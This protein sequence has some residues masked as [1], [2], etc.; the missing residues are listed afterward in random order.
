MFPS[1][2]KDFNLVITQLLYTCTKAPLLT[3]VPILFNF[4]IISTVKVTPHY[5]ICDYNT[6]TN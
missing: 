1:L 3:E 2:C 6:V 5:T 4:V